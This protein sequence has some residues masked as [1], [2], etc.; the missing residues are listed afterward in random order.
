MGNTFIRFFSTIEWTGFYF[1][2]FGKGFNISY[3]DRIRYRPLFSERNGYR[4]VLYLGSL[5]IEYLD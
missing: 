4:K 1:R 5:R 2:I 3:I